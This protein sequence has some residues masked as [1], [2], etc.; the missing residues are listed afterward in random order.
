MFIVLFIIPV[1]IGLF[2]LARYI[3]ESSKIRVKKKKERRFVNV[4][5]LE[6]SETEDENGEF[7]I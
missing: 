5:T 3:P 1:I 7:P 4:A 6:E 2:F